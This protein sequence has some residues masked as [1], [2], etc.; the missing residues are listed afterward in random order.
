MFSITDYFLNLNKLKN[1]MYENLNAEEVI[2]IVLLGESGVGKTNLINVSMGKEFQQNSDS[3]LSSSFVSSDYK[4][5]N[6]V[7][8]YVL[9]DTAGQESYRSLNKIFIKN[10]KVVIFV[11]SIEN[12]KSFQELDYWV[13]I[14]KE[15]LGDNSIYAIIGNKSDLYDEQEV[16]DEEAEKYAEEQ[17]MK[18]KFTSALADAKGVKSFLNELISDYVKKIDPEYTG[19]IVEKKKEKTSNVKLVPIPKPKKEK[20]K[21]C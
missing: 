12:Y 17:N 5:G 16:K 6:K 3:S 10:T 9:W 7:Y 1:K 20:K 11:Y 18:I 13:N 2:K 19:E 8:T 4:V 14:A 21:W 15:E